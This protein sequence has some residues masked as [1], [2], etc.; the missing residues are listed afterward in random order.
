MLLEHGSREG[1]A[2]GGSQET[3]A[4]Q[5]KQE[6]IVVVEFIESRTFRRSDQTKSTGET[7][8]ITHIANDT[9]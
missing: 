8:T 3:F 7:I 2:I 5:V 4:D 6:R 9:C 1:V